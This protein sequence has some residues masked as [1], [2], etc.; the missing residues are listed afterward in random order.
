MTHITHKRIVQ[1][2]R[3][4]QLFKNDSQFAT[5]IFRIDHKRNEIV[6]CFD[7]MSKM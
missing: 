3:F 2:G 7:C 6:L 4:L 1:A 5:P